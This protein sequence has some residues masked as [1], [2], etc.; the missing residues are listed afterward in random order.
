M[1]YF[2]VPTYGRISETKKF[3]NSLKK[4]IEKDYLVVL[5]DDHPNNVIF[6]ILKKIKI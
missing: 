2:I 4:S 5:I 3:L 6:F 1:I